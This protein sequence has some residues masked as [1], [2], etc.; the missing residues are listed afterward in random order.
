MSSQH[1]NVFVRH[2]GRVHPRWKRLLN[3]WLW[4]LAKHEEDAE[5][6]ARGIGV[7]ML[8]GVLPMFGQSF[9]AIALA[10]VFRGSRI[11]AAAMTFVSNPLTTFPIFFFDYWLGCAVLGKE[12]LPISEGDFTSW[13]R[14]S[15]LGL[16]FL[17]AI[18]FGGALFGGVAG[19]MSYLAARPIV[20]RMQARRRERRMRAQQAEI[21]RS[22]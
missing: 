11:I 9:V 18:F 17:V 16:E 5:A 13:E 12:M 10:W 7:G 14:F 1:H 8:A 3:Y 19:V 21:S 4:R 20:N 15:A 22:A 2:A 6:I